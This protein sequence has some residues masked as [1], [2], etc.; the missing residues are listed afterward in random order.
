MFLNTLTEVKK[1]VNLIIQEKSIKTLILLTQ[2]L[3]KNH[4]NTIL[5]YVMGMEI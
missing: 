3:V 2:A 1:D 4:G 5:V